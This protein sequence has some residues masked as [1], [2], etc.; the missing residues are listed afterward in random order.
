MIR[1]DI[2]K[3]Q[4]DAIVNPSNPELHMGRGTSWAIYNAAGETE[5][6]NACRKIGGCEVGK[7]VLT[8]GFALPAKFIIHAVCP[9]WRDGGEQDK[10]YLKNAY[11]CALQIAAEYGFQ[12]VAF[13]LLSS[14]FYGWP[15]AEAF[16]LATTVISEFLM[17]HDMTVY[18]VLYDHESVEVSKKL[19]SKIEEYIDDH[20]VEMKDEGYFYQKPTFECNSLPPDMM[21]HDKAATYP[22]FS[23]EP[24][25]SVPRSSNTS[26]KSRVPDFVKKLSVPK[27]RKLD[28][29]MA[30][31]D[32][33]FSR[34]LL[35]LIDERGLKDSDVY[36]K[37]NIDRRLFS[38]IRKDVNYAPTKKT[39]LAFAIALE[40]SLDE[41]KDL[42]MKAGYAFSNSSKSD[43]II[44]FF[45]E[46]RNYNVFEINEVLFFYGQP[47]LGE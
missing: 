22:Y 31:M 27:G 23:D 16:H 20:Y 4:V 19:F 42:L 18:L 37:A 47:I 41:T 17:E 38:K 11:H 34:M 29:L 28:E 15:K 24:G 8:K 30:H 26:G 9:T 1:N 14:G 32:E 6:T 43:V 5:L 7:A 45:I 46:N 13:P 39:V 33:T 25:K 36:H 35:R 3:M 21:V 12:S 2:T 44:S 10:A 40:L